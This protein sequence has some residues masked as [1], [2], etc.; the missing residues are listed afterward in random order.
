[1]PSITR[2]SRRSL[3]LALVS[4]LLLVAIGAGS[5]LAQSAVP[6][7]RPTAPPIVTD[8]GAT[9]AVP[10]P[11]RDGRPAR[12]LRP[13]HRQPRRPH[14]DDLLVVRRRGLLRPQGRDRDPHRRRIRHH[15]LGR[16][17]A[18]GHQ[19][20]CASTWRSST[21]TRSPSTRRCSSTAASTDRWPARPAPSSLLPTGGAPRGAPPVRVCGASF[22][23]RP[24]PRMDGHL[25][26]PPDRTRT[27]HPLRRLHTMLT[28]RTPP[29]TGGG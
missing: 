24:L 14:P 11:T 8:D 7:E 28:V 22:A 18:R 5:A 6:S 20:H 26:A 25:G 17:A 10:N 13:R 15:H 9:P 23:W 1:M 27:T 29:R 3:G 19:P 16:D 21:R 2:R 4:G 12:A